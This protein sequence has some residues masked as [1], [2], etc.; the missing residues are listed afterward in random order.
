ML[1]NPARAETR[2]I[3]IDAPLTAVFDLVADPQNLPRWAPGFARSVEPSGRD[4]VVD[5]G[6]NQTRI[7]VRSSR[8]HGTIDLLSAEDSRVGAFTRVLPNGDGSEFQ[9]TLFFP[10]DAPGAA[11]AGQLRTVEEE[12]QAVRN[13]CEELT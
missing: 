12:L 1:T 5:D 9:F 2:T 7:A 8:E 4:W 10:A 3:F 13:L 11:V 6:E